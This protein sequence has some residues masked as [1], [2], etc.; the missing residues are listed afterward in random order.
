MLYRLEGKPT[1]AG[2]NRYPDVENGQWYTDAVLWATQN[3]IVTGYDNGN[4]GT[5]DKI[6]RE[7]IAT[8]LYRY[9]KYKGYAVSTSAALSRYSDAGKVSDWAG[10]AMSWANAEGIITGRTETTLVPDGAASRAEVATM[11]MRFVE[12]YAG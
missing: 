10:T 9:T 6:T 8:I 7:Q 11:L 5:N 12:R 2:T 4:F 1:V 3:G